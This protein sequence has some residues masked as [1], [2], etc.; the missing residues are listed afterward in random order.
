[1]AND[2]DNQDP[3]NEYHNDSQ[4]RGND[5]LC[6][7][8]SFHIS[9][10]SGTQQVNCDHVCVL[11]ET[12]KSRGRGVCVKGESNAHSQLTYIKIELWSQWEDQD[13]GQYLHGTES[14]YAKKMQ[15]RIESC[16]IHISLIILWIVGCVKSKCVKIGAK[17]NTSIL[18]NQKDGML[19]PMKMEN[20]DL[21]IRPIW[22]DAL[23]D[24]QVH[25]FQY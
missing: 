8:V 13:Q 2:H 14:L 18:R 9:S 12:T 17:T 4:S 5:P 23:L 1:M 11:T 20:T 21:P 7:P 16:S 19:K 15:T 10:S 3:L 24:D 6:I 25:Y 22:L